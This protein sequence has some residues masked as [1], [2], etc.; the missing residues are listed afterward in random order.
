MGETRIKYNNTYEKSGYREIFDTEENEQKL[1]VY[2]KSNLQVYDV[3]LVGEARIEQE[4]FCSAKFTFSVM[5]DESITFNQGDAVSVKYDG[6]VIFYGYVFSKSRDKDEIIRVVAYDQMR[7]LKNRR[8]YTRGSMRLDE[9]IKK[10]A[11]DNSMRTGEFDSANII[12]PAVACDNVSLL[13][14]MVKACKDARRISGKRYIVYDAGGYINLKNEDN[15]TAE[16]QIDS[17]QIENYVYTD[18]IDSGVYNM[19]SLYN[20]TPRLNLREIVNVCD[21]ENME[22]WGT[23][24]LSKKATDINSAEEEAEKLLEEYNRINREIVL[25]GAIG[26][27]LIFPGVWLWVTLTAGDLALDGYV[28][29]IK[30]EHIFEKNLYTVNLYI[31]GSDM[32]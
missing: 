21:K 6:S 16:V 15:L 14:V 12:L 24:I 2:I 23:L 10:I 4:E 26:N 22:K 20:D 29:C 27:V 8:S 5:K 9:V 32:N 13:D 18:S 11:N 1:K 30:A 31:D 28:R 19:I 25:K 17:S 3:V 7:Y